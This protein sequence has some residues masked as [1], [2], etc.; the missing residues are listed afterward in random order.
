MPGHLFGIE[1]LK[2]RVSTIGSFKQ[3]N[4]AYV[5][6]LVWK[7][8]LGFVA[9]HPLGGGFV[10]YLVD[11]IEVPGSGDTPA[12]IEF[13]RAFHSIYFEVLGEHGYPGLVI[14]LLLAGSTFLLLRRL[15]KKARAFPELQWVV[16]LSDAL[17]SGLA[18]FMA[19]GAFVGIAFPP[20]FWYFI[21]MGVC[22]NAYMWRVERISIEPSAGWRAMATATSGMIPLRT[23]SLAGVDRCR[24]RRNWT[25][26]LRASNID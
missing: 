2:C 3:E 1:R 11:S 24:S 17:Q 26:Q 22:L 20:M 4:S 14:F 6:I 15:A 13:G 12:H 25:P 8:T 19:S 10:T 21:S 9:S 23:T 18:V 16:G 7:W 5:R